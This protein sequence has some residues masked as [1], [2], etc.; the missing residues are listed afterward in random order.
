[1]KKRE[2][3]PPRFDELPDLCTPEQVMAF[4]QLSRNGTYELLRTG[5]IPSIKFGRLIRVRKATLIQ[6]SSSR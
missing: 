2:S 6:E 4:L 3:N 5:A 1:M